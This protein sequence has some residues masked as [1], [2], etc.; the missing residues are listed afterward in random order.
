M[1]ICLICPYGMSVPGGVQ[2][3]TLLLAKQFV[4]NGHEVLV[5]APGQVSQEAGFLPYQVFDS[6]YKKR[7]RD[8]SQT[9]LTIRSRI[10]TGFDRIKNLRS[11]NRL[12]ASLRDGN[13]G[14]DE[15]V[16]NIRMHSHSD[17]TPENQ[18]RS[19]AVFFFS[20]GKTLAV[21]ANGS[22]AP[23]SLSLR[24]AMTMSGVIKSW[25]PD[26][27]H[28]H[29]PFAPILSV[30]AMLSARPHKRPVVAATF[31]RLGAGGGYK[32]VGFLLRPLYKKADLCYAVSKPAQH[33]LAKVVKAGNA[34]RAKV[35]FNGIDTVSLSK[36]LPYKSAAASRPTICFVG[37]LE[38]RKGLEIL[39]QALSDTAL[40]VDVVILGSGPE[41]ARLQPKYASSKNIFWLGRVGDEEKLSRIKAS[42]LLISPAITGE[43]FGIVILEAMA[44]A[45]PVVCS[46]I[47]G[48]RASAG[49]A[50]L[51]VK[52]NDPEDL[53]KAITDVLVDNDLRQDLIRK[54]LIRAEQMSIAN[55]ANIYLEDFQNALV[56]MED[57]PA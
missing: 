22:V 2:N 19:E 41:M 7:V 28:V 17:L 3:Q 1:K 11:K 5:I 14:K 21:R 47:P 18:D 51:F 38:P 15:S 30:A 8:K 9:V 50:A 25:S 31:H 43:S 4:N 35:V 33:T 36:V 24:S 6:G 29:E 32:S 34:R 13:Q 20:A 10:S 27:L 57:R 55:L 23:I 56:K 42:S 39:L 52:P 40:D 45:V 48:H 37:R 53:K 54:G 49:E 26:I 46:N 12:P 16:T 44:L